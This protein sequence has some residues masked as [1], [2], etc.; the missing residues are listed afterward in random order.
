MTSFSMYTRTCIQNFYKK[1]KNKILLLNTLWKIE[2]CKCYIIHYV[3][4]PL[5]PGIKIS[6]LKN[7]ICIYWKMH[8]LTIFFIKSI[9]LQANKLEPRSGPT[10]VGPDL[11][12]SLFAAVQ[13][14][15]RSVSW[16]KWVNDNYHNNCF[17]LK[18]CL[19]TFGAALLV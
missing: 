10:Y 2:I 14:T 17:A 8:I 7:F 19:D 5:Q 13:N 18:V 11:C 6:R 4:N 12:S 1:S 15:N 9:V 3:F 16:L